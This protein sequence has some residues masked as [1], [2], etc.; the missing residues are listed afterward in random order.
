MDI[1]NEPY[2]TITDTYNQKTGEHLKSTC[3]TASGDLIWEEGPTPSKNVFFL[4]HY[5]QAPWLR[6]WRE[7]D[8]T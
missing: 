5:L 2:V 7:A 3:L 6:F 1:R 8:I 4:P